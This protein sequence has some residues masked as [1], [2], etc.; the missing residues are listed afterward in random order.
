M[1]LDAPHPIVMLVASAFVALAVAGTGRAATITKTDAPDP[2]APGGNITYTITVTP[3]GPDSHFSLRD[4]I[5]TGTSFVSVTPGLPTCGLDPTLTFVTCKLGTPVVPVTV[6][7]VVN[8]GAA[9]ASGTVITNTLQAQ[10]TILSFPDDI[11]VLGEATA[12]TTVASPTPVTL[13]SFTA[14]RDRS[15]VLLRWRTASEFD[16]LGFNVYAVIRGRRVRVNPSL[17]ASR[18]RTQGAAYA[19]RH[20]LRKDKAPSRYWLQVVGV[21]GSRSWRSATTVAHRTAKKGELPRPHESDSR[22]AKPTA[23]YGFSGTS[24]GCTVAAGLASPAFS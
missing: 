21:D 1:C 19:L 22:R 15:G 16:V 5:P 17:V 12:Y 13:R 14:T 2:V 20:R 9:V 6:T 18:G 4:A 8:V 23:R 11:I 10:Y 7:L 3:D 24:L